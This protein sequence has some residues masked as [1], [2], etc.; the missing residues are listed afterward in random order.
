MNL[1]IITVMQ[2]QVFCES[3]CELVHN[4]CSAQSEEDVF[5]RIE[6]WLQ[7]RHIHSESPDEKRQTFFSHKKSCLTL[8]RFSNTNHSIRPFNSTIK[9]RKNNVTSIH[10]INTEPLGGLVLDDI[11]SS[12]LILKRFSKM[13]SLQLK[14]SISTGGDDIRPCEISINRRAFRKCS[15]DPES[16]LK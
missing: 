9:K 14:Q 12:S 8:N 13:N 15:L 6:A 5:D 16:N 4:K 2:A 11:S 7:V 10:H 1:L 3:I